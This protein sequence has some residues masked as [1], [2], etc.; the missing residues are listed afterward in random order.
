MSVQIIRGDLIKLAKEGQFDVIGHGCNC[1]ST[2]K[3]GIAPKMAEA[4]GCDK[5]PM[6]LLQ[7]PLSAWIKLGNIDWQVRSEHFIYVIN[8]YTQYHWNGNSQYCIPL[9]YDALKMCLRK[10]AIFMKLVGAKN[11][12]LP[13]IGCGLAGGNKD[14]VHSIIENEMHW[15]NVTIVE[16]ENE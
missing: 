13:W 3:R 16:F 10:T 11:I 1:F 15:L 14:E 5:F 4:F 9:D 8:M 2:M 7:D 6:E 12:G